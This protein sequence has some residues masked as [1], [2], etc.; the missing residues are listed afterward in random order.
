MQQVV[1]LTVVELG[2]LRF[3][4]VGPP[5]LSGIGAICAYA[6]IAVVAFL[7]KDISGSRPWTCILGSKTAHR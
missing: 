1:R 3:K 5:A 7:S 2:P 4:A 6:Q